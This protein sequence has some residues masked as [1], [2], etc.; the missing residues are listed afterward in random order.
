MSIYLVFRGMIA[1]LVTPIAVE[2]LHFM[3]VL[4]CVQPISV[5]FLRMG[6]HFFGTDKEA[7]NFCFVSR[8]H[9]KLDNLCDR[10]EWSIGVGNGGNFR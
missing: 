4:V 10:E 6:C 8:G 9:D 2:L 5:I 7:C 1:S 3:V